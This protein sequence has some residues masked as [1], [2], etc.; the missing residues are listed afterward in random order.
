MTPWLPQKIVDA[1]GF[2][3]VKNESAAEILK[4]AQKFDRAAWMRKRWEDSKDRKNL[5]KKISEAQLKRYALEARR[6]TY[7]IDKR[8]KHESPNGISLQ[9]AQYKN[10]DRI[11]RMEKKCEELG[12]SQKL[13]LNLIVDDFLAKNEKVK[14]G[15]IS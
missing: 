13:F 15:F 4:P 8:K 11:A 6:K 7:Q 9:M 5:G 10:K 2:D 12:I 3:P 14:I 1:L